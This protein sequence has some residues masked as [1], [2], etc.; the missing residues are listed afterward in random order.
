MELLTRHKRLTGQNKQND[1]K[2]T[3][4]RHVLEVLANVFVTVIFQVC[5]QP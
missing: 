3:D 5:S 4:D 1:A 2:K